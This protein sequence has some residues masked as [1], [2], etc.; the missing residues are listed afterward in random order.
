MRVVAARSLERV[1]EVGVWVCSGG[2]HSVGEDV[3]QVE[4]I[5]TAPATRVYSQGREDHG[6]FYL[7]QQTGNNTP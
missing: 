5:S 1:L 3:V 4:D 6:L 7:P 2:L